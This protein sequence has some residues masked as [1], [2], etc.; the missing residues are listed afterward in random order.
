MQLVVNDLS[1]KFPCQDER[2]GQGIMENFIEAYYLVKDVLDNSSILLDKDYRTFE[3]A[4]NYRIEHWLNDERVDIELKRRFRRIINQSFA[5]D[6][7]TF[8]EEYHWRL[9]AEFEYKGVVSRS[10]QLAYEIE[11]VLISF[12]TEEYWNNDIVRGIY[13]YLNELGEMFSE[14]ADIPNISSKD[15][16]AKFRNEQEIIIAQQERDSIRSGMD[17]VL[18]KDKAFPNLVFCAKALKQLQSEIGGAEA[19]QV[20]R[21]LKELQAVAEEMK[22]GFAFEK[23]TH[24]TPETPTTL[25][26]FEE[27]HRIMLPTGKTQLFSWHVRFTGGYAGRIFFEPAPQESKVYIGHIGRKL[28]TA[29]YH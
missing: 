20:F 28:P 2:E 4:R 21:R 10:C 3:L 13:T 8:E 17:I 25:Q 23:L 19:G 29:T 18:C 26:M 1:A 14:K 12:L 24:A 22:K 6:S 15:N 7:E 11:G 9:D 16:A 5:F 27:E